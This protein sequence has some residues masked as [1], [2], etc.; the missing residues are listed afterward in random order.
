M[1]VLDLECCCLWVSCIYSLITRD[2]YLDSVLYLG[3]VL[4]KTPHW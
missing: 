4:L 3:S 1:R 2:L